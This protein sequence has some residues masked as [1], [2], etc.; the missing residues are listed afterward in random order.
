[1]NLKKFI[2]AI[3]SKLWPS[4]TRATFVNVGEGTY[5]YGKRSMIWDSTGANGTSNAAALAANTNSQGRYLLVKTGSD[6]DHIV[7]CG[8]GDTPIGVCMDAYDANNTDVPAEVA[9]L[10]VHPG[11][12]RMVTDSS[13]SN[14]NYVKCG[15]NGQA[16]AAST[17]N[18]S[19][20][21]ALFGTDT[22]SAAG[23][24]ITVQ[25]TI[26]AKYVF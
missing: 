11:T 2:K 21:I 22:T 12:L 1:M 5:H 20:G 19:F 3:A 18:V 26:P 6:A 7:V 17:T 16:V 13:I 15:A 9:L 8:A 23:D 25:H 4:R 24:V 14:G 10:G